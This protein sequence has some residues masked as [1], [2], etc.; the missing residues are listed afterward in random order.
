MRE[1]GNIVEDYM[2]YR[3]LNHVVCITAGQWLKTR[4]QRWAGLQIKT[5]LGLK[6]SAKSLWSDMR[7]SDRK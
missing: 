7:K 4:Q 2:E 3:S 5:S 1:M 6:S